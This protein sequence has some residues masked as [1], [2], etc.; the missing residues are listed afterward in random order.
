M[1]IYQ[2]NDLR[3]SSGGIKGR[4]RKVK[5]KYELG[6]FSVLPSLSESDVRKKIRARG[7]AFKVKLV[8]VSYANINIPSKGI[9][10]RVK[11][12]KVISSPSNRDY[13]RKKIISRGTIIG[14]QL[15]KAKVV[16]RPGQ[17]GVLN[18]ILLEEKG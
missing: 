18:A 14:T 2:G 11:I 13:D 3:K 8:K 15:G 9:T 5:R 16:S 10:Q 1:G 12:L 7:G 6:R 17:D 4:H